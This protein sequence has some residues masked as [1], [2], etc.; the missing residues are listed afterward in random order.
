MASNKLPSTDLTGMIIGNNAE[1]ATME[2]MSMTVGGNGF[3]FTNSSSGCSGHE[4]Y[5]FTAFTDTVFSAITFADL[6]SGD[7][8]IV[9]ITIPANTTVFFNFTALTLASGTGIAYFV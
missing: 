2:L 6:Y 5:S 4:Y 8:D 7:A 1:R 9:G 3:T